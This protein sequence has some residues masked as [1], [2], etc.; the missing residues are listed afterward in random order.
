MSFIY[1]LENNEL[2]NVD[3]LACQIKIL[4]PP[5][6]ILINF[7]VLLPDVAYCLEREEIHKIMNEIHVKLC[8][9]TKF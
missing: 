9:Y 7:V 5:M 3:Y 4:A 6:V 1:Y 2:L 8:R